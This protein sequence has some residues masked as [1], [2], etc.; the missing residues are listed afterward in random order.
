MTLETQSPPGAAARAAPAVRTDVVAVIPAYQCAATVGEVVAGTLRHL[1]RVVVCD[2]GSTDGTGDVARAAGAR[3][4]ANEENRGKG[5]ALTR[6]ASVAL[7]GEAGAGRPAA[8]ALVDGDGQ[9]DP[10]DLPGLLAVWDEGRWDLLVGARLKEK[11]AIPPHRY[12]TNTIGSKLLS[13]IT[14]VG[15]ED[16]QSGYRLISADLFEELGLASTGYAIESEMLIKA[17][18][19]GARIGH[20]PVRTIYHDRVP[21]FYRP[22]T[23]TVR[24]TAA[25]VYHRMVDDRRGRRG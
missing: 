25:S 20:A 12:W 10:D 11:E 18:R 16:S 5:H 22:V 8:L 9:H 24:I 19:R 21:S 4:V 1:G 23:D 2:D 17:A 14:G 3:V 13:W 7:S 15:L 6:A